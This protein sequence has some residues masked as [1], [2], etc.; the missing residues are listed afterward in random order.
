MVVHGSEVTAMASTD[1]DVSQTVERKIKY[2]TIMPMDHI[3]ELAKAY[4]LGSIDHSDAADLYLAN[5][6]LLNRIDDAEERGLTPRDVV[7]QFLRPL[8]SSKDHCG[9]TS[10][11]SRCISC[12][13]RR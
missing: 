4:I 2:P 7:I 5:K 3:S 13:Q 8:F 12:S 11:Q 10:C 1:L 6:T 9:C